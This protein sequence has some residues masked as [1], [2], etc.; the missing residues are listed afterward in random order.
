D[1]TN[2]EG[3]NEL[4]KVPISPRQTLGATIRLLPPRRDTT[5]QGCQSREGRWKSLGAKSSQGISR[6]IK[7]GRGSAF[8]QKLRPWRPEV[9]SAYVRLRRDKNPKSTVPG[10]VLSTILHYFALF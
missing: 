8:A 2:A 6:Q 3:T 1:P 9:P 5:R 10:R 7:G 4:C